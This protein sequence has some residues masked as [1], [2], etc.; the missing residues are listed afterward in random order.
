MEKLQ[1][2]VK[3]KVDF[4]QELDFLETILKGN[5]VED[6]ENF[7]RPSEKFVLDPF[8]LDNMDK[9]LEL[10]HNNLDKQIFIKV[11]CDVDGFTSSAYLR[12]FILKINPEAR[13]EYRLDFNKRHGLFYEDVAHFKKGELGL[14]IIPDASILVKEAQQ[15]KENLGDVPILILD[16]H[17]IEEDNQD[18][19]DYA[20]VINCMVGEYANKF[21]S[22][23]GVVHK[24]CSAYCSKYGISQA[25][26][27]YY[28]DLV[29]LG[30]TADAMDLRSLESRYYVL[31]GLREEN[32]HNE[33]I[34]EMMERNPENFF[35]GNLT[36]HSVGW[37]I[38]PLIN[39]TIRYGKPEEQIDLFRALCGEQEDREYQPRRKHKDDPKPPVEIH[40]LQKTMA[41]VCDNVK[42]R[43]DTEVRKFMTKIEEVIE[44]EHLEQNSIIIVDGSNILTKTTVTGLVANKVASKYKRPVLILKNYTNDTFGGSGR[45]YDKGMIEDLRGFLG[46]F[47]LFDKLA[48]HS[49]AFGIEIKKDKIQELTNSYN[50]KM[51]LSNLVTIHEV[52]YEVPADKLKLKDIHNVANA[53]QIWG[54]SVDEPMFAITNLR[55]NAQDINA[56]G[57]NQGFIRFVYRGIPFIKKYCPKGDYDQMVLKDRKT[58]G[59]SKKDLVLN[60]ICSFT[61]N[62][63][64]G[65]I[66]PQV[67]IWYYDSTVATNKDIEEDWVF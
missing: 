60:L 17:E 12:Q 52:D 44:K 8:S 47:E 58:I 22:G 63:Y 9:G 56:Y 16:H 2:K 1:W 31:E 67:K 33:L 48:G 45:N 23:V 14:I 65:K 66:T 37:S 10:L 51:P 49:N 18:M 13:I 39:A 61:L 46:E 57:E 21:L 20:T 11:D 15:I 32:R 35:G 26:A 50:E 59:S 54:N 41:R 42:S 19:F 64:E 28:L 36:I 62:E 55:I 34:N 5:G 6:I 43:Q 27:N 7:L 40:S 53:Y 3:H 30:L 38:G 4:T 29:A 24:F 25:V